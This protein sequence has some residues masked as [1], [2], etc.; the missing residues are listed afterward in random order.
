MKKNVG[1]DVGRQ[2]FYTHGGEIVN[3][4]KYFGHQH[5]GIQ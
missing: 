2:E 5:Q 1:K 4:H 3:W